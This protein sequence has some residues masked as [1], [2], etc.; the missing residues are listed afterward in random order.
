MD[1]CATEI[2]YRGDFRGGLTGVVVLKDLSAGTSTTVT[3]CCIDAEMLLVTFV[4]DC[5]YDSNM[6]T[7]R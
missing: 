3:S 5:G 7:K 1:E 2:Q 6:E 4:V